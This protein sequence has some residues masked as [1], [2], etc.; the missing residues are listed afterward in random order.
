MRKLSVIEEIRD[1]FPDLEE[2]C[3]VMYGHDDAVVGIDA[4]K[5]VLIY[6][7]AKFVETF[8][9]RD[10]MTPD[11]AMEYFDYNYAGA[12]MG[13]HTPIWLDDFLE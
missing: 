4:Y 11:E 3:V 6:S 1:R 12:Y 10:G 2:E 7:V 5:M 9:E 13:E 8:V